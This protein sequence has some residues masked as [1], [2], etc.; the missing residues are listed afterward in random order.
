MERTVSNSPRG[1]GGF[2]SLRILIDKIEVDVGS[3]KRSLAD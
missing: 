2:F 3:K 1:S